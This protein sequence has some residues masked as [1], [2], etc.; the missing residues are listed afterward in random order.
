MVGGG[1][2]DGH[3]GE[4]GAKEDPASDVQEAVRTSARPRPGAHH[5]AAISGSPVM[6]IIYILTSQKKIHLVPGS[7]PAPRATSDLF[8]H[9]QLS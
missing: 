9:W 4:A 1:G 6:R 5:V 8:S 3:E 2:K 7:S